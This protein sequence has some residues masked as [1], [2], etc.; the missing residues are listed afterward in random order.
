MNTNEKNEFKKFNFE[1]YLVKNN[2][3]NILL[4]EFYS[5]LTDDINNTDFYLTKTAN[6]LVKKH[7]FKLNKDECIY[8]SYILL[9]NITNINNINNY[10][11][12]GSIYYKEQLNYKYFDY[13]IKGSYLLFSWKNKNT[14]NE[15]QCELQK[16]I[17]IKLISLY[18][19]AIL[20][21]FFQILKTKNNRYSILHLVQCNQYHDDTYFE[22]N[23]I[24]INTIYGYL[25]I[26]RKI[27]NNYKFIISIDEDLKNN[28]NYEDIKYL[29]Y[30]INEYEKE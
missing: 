20:H 3:I 18:Y 1:K 7:Y 12:P 8:S 13:N 16:D 26:K 21:H 19:I 5:N 15:A 25:F 17:F 28:I 10:I 22:Q 9:K 23:N 30:I 11:F 4:N 14:E 24:F 6:K 29:Y 2:S 27:L